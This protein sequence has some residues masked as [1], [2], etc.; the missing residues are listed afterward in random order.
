MSKKLEVV[1][2]T[3]NSKL[4]ISKEPYF[5][6]LSKKFY[7]YV[8]SKLITEPPVFVFGRKCKQRRCVG[9]F[10]DEINGYK[11]SGQIMWANSLENGLKEMLDSVNEYF[12]GQTPYNSILVNVYR[13]G[14]DY[15]SAHSD[16]ENLS[17]GAG[18]CS[19][20]IGAT[21]K[22]VIRSK[23]TRE[24]KHTLNIENGMLMLMS[25]DFQKEFTHEIIKQK[26]I[27]EERISFTFRRHQSN[28]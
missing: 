22:F 12:P 19:F 15:I 10:S 11:Y 7:T 18:V 23:A 8:K 16:N 14:N 21:R 13:D 24:I 28:V 17:I 2:K 9:F 20:S 27:K 4:S 25:G 1:F 5:E 3:I 6:D 26:N